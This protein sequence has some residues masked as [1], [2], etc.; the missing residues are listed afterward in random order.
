MVAGIALCGI[1]S[2]K[3]ALPARGSTDRSLPPGPVA[4]LIEPGKALLAYKSVPDGSGGEVVAIVLRSP[5][6]SE[7]EGATSWDERVSYTC[8]LLMVNVRGATAWITG[9][10]ASVVD[11]DWNE[12][13]RRA[14]TL[15]LNDGI[16]LSP[17]S[18]TFLNENPRGGS[19]SYTFAF[20]GGVWHLESATRFYKDDDR[21]SHG[22]VIAKEEAAFPKD[23]GLISMERFDPDHIDRALM[24]NKS[25]VE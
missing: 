1:A 22:V 4:S 18:V 21:S 6:E 8:E 2:A 11:C 20:S 23:F 3:C 10:S 25:V 13:N 9:R 15:G 24:K 14:P 19:Y 12:F 16:E 7:P 17:N 5:G